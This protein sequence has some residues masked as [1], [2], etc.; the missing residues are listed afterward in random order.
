MV[1]VPRNSPRASFGKARRD[2][3]EPGAADGPERWTGAGPTPGPGQYGS[4][5]LPSSCCSRSA[6]F[7]FGTSGRAGPRQRACPGPGSYAPKVLNEGPGYSYRPPH[8]E[9]SPRVGGGAIS[10][11]PGAYGDVYKELDGP[12]FSIGQARQKQDIVQYPGPG[13]YTGG[14]GYT[15]SPT[16]RRPQPGFGFGTSVREPGSLRRTPGPGQYTVARTLG[17]V[18]FS[19]LPKRPGPA[20]E[21]TG[22]GPGAHNVRQDFD[23]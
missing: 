7:V 14:V 6:A 23:E 22:P 11:G 3:R 16:K 21:S 12:K 20:P 5:S 9:N 15:A 4:Q 2:A 19:M 13:H 17:G 10:P 8:V 1:L 18:E